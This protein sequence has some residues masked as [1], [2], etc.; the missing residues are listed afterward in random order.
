MANNQPKLDLEK[1]PSPADEAGDFSTPDE[2]ADVREK[3][4]E[5]E[6]LKAKMGPIGRL[7]GSTDSSRTIA[8]VAVAMCLIFMICVFFKAYDPVTG[9]PDHAFNL[10][11]LLGSIVTGCIGF[12]FGTRD[13]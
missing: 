12:I 3:N 7:I 13:N 5:L 11:S 1:S 8:F 4:H 2:K 10:V 9:M 6:I